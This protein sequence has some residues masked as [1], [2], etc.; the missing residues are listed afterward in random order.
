[1]NLYYIPFSIEDTFNK[2]SVDA[3]HGLTDILKIYTLIQCYSSDRY[4]DTTIFDSHKD[5]LPELKRTAGKYSN[6]FC[7]DTF[8]SNYLSLDYNFKETF[9]DYFNNYKCNTKISKTAF[10]KFLNDKV[11]PYQVLYYKDI[12]NYYDEEITCGNTR[13]ELY[14]GCYRLLG[15]R[16]RRQQQEE[17]SFVFS[18]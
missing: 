18:R 3:E 4:I 9:W 10:A 7:D 5:I 12:V 16:D 8:A 15:E 17:R 1:M 11:Y 13:T 6:T 14:T 2:F